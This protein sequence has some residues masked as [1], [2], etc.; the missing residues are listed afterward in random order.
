MPHYFQSPILFSMS[1]SLIVNR[2]RNLMKLETICTQSRLTPSTCRAQCEED[3]DDGPI[4]FLKY[5]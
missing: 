5:S 3:G 2:S 4:S 1:A